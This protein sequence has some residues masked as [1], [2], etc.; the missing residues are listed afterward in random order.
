MSLM[1]NADKRTM[2]YKFASAYKIS[3]IHSKHYRTFII[4]NSYI[5]Y[6]L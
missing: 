1:R 6:A 4:Y 2:Y 5:L 3:K